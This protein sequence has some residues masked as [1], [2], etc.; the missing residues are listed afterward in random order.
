M[1]LTFNKC[2]TFFTT[3]QHYHSWSYL[4]QFVT[5]ITHQTTNMTQPL[6]LTICYM[7]TTVVGSKTMVVIVTLLLGQ[8]DATCPFPTNKYSNEFGNLGMICVLLLLWGYPMMCHVGV[9]CF[10]IKS[11]WVYIACFISCLLFVVLNLANE[12][13]HLFQF[14]LIIW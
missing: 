7:N 2:S 4:P 1:M 9:Q 6:M 10:N 14:M 12:I 5:T 3:I 11:S 13:N 8:K